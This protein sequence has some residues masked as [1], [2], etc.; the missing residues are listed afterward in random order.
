[1]LDL[2]VDGGHGEALEQPWLSDVVA[3]CP[4]AL[5]RHKFC[6]PDQGNPHPRQGPSYSLAKQKSL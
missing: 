6:E 2:S 3:A 5:F 4:A 1:M